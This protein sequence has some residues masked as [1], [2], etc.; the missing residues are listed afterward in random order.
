M[1]V[2]SRKVKESIRIGDSI[3]IVVLGSG[4]GRV[5]LG[6]SAPCD[7]AIKRSELLAPKPMLTAA[8]GGDTLPTATAMVLS[9]VAHQ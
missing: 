5:R 8:N 2:L 1:L 9:S 4:G 7:T 6:I 3:E